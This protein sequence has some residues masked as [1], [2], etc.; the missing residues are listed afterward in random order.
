MW[1]PSVC[2]QVYVSPSTCV[3]AE[4]KRIGVLAWSLARKSTFVQFR[5]YGKS[6]TSLLN[7]PQIQI[8]PSIPTLP[9]ILFSLPSLFPLLVANSL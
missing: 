6:A 4:D 9:N 8:Y 7:L 2:I 1:I 5:F 3:S